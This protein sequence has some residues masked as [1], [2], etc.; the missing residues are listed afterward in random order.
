MK[1]RELVG[2]G[3]VLAGKGSL[4]D[5]PGY[6]VEQFRDYGL[7]LAVR[8]RIPLSREGLREDVLWALEQTLRHGT[9]RAK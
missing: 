1:L 8:W 3:K 7:W 5:L 9:P 2:L 6:V 4:D